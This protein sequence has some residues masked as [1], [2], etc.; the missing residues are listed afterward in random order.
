MR[1]KICN[2]LVQPASAVSLGQKTH[3]AVLEMPCIS[4]YNYEVGQI[5]TQFCCHI[6]GY[7]HQWKCIF[8]ATSW[9]WAYISQ[10]FAKRDVVERN[11]PLCSA[12][13]SLEN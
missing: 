4:L 1:G 9:Q 7:T 13:A 12:P 3:S 6:H 2:L 5:K 11:I 8:L 10:Y